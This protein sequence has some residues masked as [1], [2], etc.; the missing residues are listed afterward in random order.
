MKMDSINSRVLN[1]FIAIGLLFACLAG[2]LTWFEL[3]GKS[4]IMNSAYNRRLMAE[5]EQ[6]LR[7]SILDRNGVILA[8]SEEKDG[9]STRLYPFSGLYTHVIG[10]DSV[11]Y[12]KSLLES[13]F[14]A[15]LLGKDGLEIID[16]FG[17]MIT[18]EKRVG[19]SLIL[20]VDN[21]LQKKA[22]ELMGSNRGAIVALN[23]KTGEIL[24]MVSTPDFNPN[25][26]GLEEKWPELVEDPNSPLLPRAVMGLYPPGSTFKVVT[27]A[28]AI[29]NGLA[30]TQFDDTGTIVIDG[31]TFKNYAG[32]AYGP[33]D[34]TKAV[35]VSSNVYFS[36]L[37]GLVGA[38]PLRDKAVKA[39]FTE[40]LTL[41]LP[42]TMSRIGT[43]D[44]GKTE[45]AATGIGQGKLLATPLQMAMISAGIANDGIIM[46]PYLV[47][48]T[49]DVTGKILKTTQ[50]QA[51]YQFTDAAVADAVTDMMIGVVESGTGTKARISGTAVAG[52]TGTAQNEKSAQGEGFDHAWFIGFAPAENPEIAVAVILEYQGKGGGQAAAPIAGSVMNTWLKSIRN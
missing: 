43:P 52:K 1:V 42:L 28:A 49:S 37:A 31:K 35:T 13:R 27:A 18:G 21:D 33:L 16:K 19:H 29:E 6:I 17:S 20:T 26:G 46:K 36:Q 12:G 24:A 25:A 5:E 38:K 44:M 7:G 15:A 47:G 45:L 41:D 34:M 40:E 3:K 50:P 22:R 4:S 9:V 32:K 30:D 10:Y 48:N 14:N 23:P 2:T 51:L 39:G 11:T 8:H